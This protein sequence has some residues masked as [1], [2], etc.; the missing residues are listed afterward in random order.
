MTQVE[1][2]FTNNIPDKGR[3]HNI[4]RI[5]TIQQQKVNN[6]INNGQS[7]WIDI[8]QKG[9]INGQQAYEKMLNAI[10][11]IQIKTTMRYHFTPTWMDRIKK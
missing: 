2:I 4:L 11:E 3:V 8:L 7:I 5:H 9:D 10:K 6:P 1:K